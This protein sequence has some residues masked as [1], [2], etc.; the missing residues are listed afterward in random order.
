MRRRLSR[1]ALALLALDLALGLVAWWGAFWL[2]FNLDIPPEF[3]RLALASSGWCVLGLAAGLVL[4]GAERQV[5][6][7]IGLPELRQLAEGVTLGAVLTALVVLMLRVPDFPRSVL[8]LQPVL[9]LLLMGAA[10][11]AWRSHAEGRALA[12]GGTPVVI[13]GSL[14]D[15]A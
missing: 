13:V 10:R 1:S 9:A 11:A 8:L 7:Y 14:D 4:R 2:R 5:W 12:P 3:A 15:A 6:T